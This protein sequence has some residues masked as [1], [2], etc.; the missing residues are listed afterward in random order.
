M[1]ISKPASM[2]NIV[3]YFLL[4]I[5]LIYAPI[6]KGQSIHNNNLEHK[7]DSLIPKQINDSTPGIVIGVVQ[8]GKLVFSKGYGLANISYGI[9][10]GPKMVYNI[11]SVSKQFLGYAFAILHVKGILNIDDPVDKY[12]KNWPKFKHTVTL[13]HLLS[14]TSGYREAYTMSNLAGRI[15][16]VDRLSREEC[17]NVV[18]KQTHLEFTPGSRYTYNSTAWVILAEILE[19]ITGVPADKWVEKNIIEPLGM[20][21]TQIESYV[22][23]VIHNAAESYSSND[24]NA[25]INEKSNRSIFGAAEVYTNIPDLVK[26]INNYR[27]AQIGGKAV[28][29]LF[30]SP[31]ILNDGSNSN[32]A[33]GIINST[34]RGLRRYT[35]TGSHEAFL[36]QV[37][38]Y[39]DYDL[40]IVTI[41]NYARKG[42]L[43]TSKIANIL[44]GEYMSS[45]SNKEYPKIKKKNL[46]QFTGLY[47]ASTFN[48]TMNI[49]ME[50]DSLTIGG[51][52]KL[53]P[54]TQ[55]SFRING[56]NSELQFKNRKNKKMQLTI[57]N[58]T[59][60]IYTRVKKWSPKKSDLTEFE[61]D[62]WSDE[63]ETVY[64]LIIKNDKLTIQHRW[65]DDIALK[66]ISKDLFKT[67]YN[68]YVKFIRNKKAELT[69]LSIYSNHSL[70][71]YFK[72][73]R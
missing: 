34:Y 27:T 36:T 72:R 60:E 55:K 35:H 73:K 38:Y 68:Y 30:L 51:K 69:G 18:K 57:I 13:R 22:G 11:G 61:A 15:I 67:N 32:Y 4:S 52:T 37:S 53:I 21:D 7:I 12:L 54:S 64:H 10:N 6:S 66:P 47:L 31:F 39:P 71:V 46:K 1:L 63:L 16:G 41:S 8:K 19:S 49:T 17:L 33:L 14:H 62:Y 28:N 56:W 48:K 50:G 44:L 43:P 24:K 45:E 58:N 3:Y 9:A 2:N 23:E 5:C 42:W 70:N 29:E 25:Y 20:H 40:G 59:K 65:L 26:W